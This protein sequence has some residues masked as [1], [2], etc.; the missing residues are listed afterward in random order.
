MEDKTM[1]ERQKD[2]VMHKCKDCE[3]LDYTVPG[4]QK[5]IDDR[6][7]FYYLCRKTK[8]FTVDESKACKFFKQKSI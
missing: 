7:D 1:R 2:K 8:V 4:S 3:Y 6:S 5:T